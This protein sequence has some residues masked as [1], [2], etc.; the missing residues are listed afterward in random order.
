[1]YEETLSYS[2]RSTWNSCRK[3]Y[4]YQYVKR[5][6]TAPTD[7][8]VEKWLQFSKGS[9]VHACLESVFKGED[10]SVGLTRVT[11]R[12]E[13]DGLDQNKRDALSELLASSRQIAQSVADWLPA[14][15]WDPVIGPDGYKLIE[16]KLT[17]KLPGW[18]GGFVGYADLIA[19]HRP[20]GLT[21]ILDWKTRSKF[22]AEN[23]GAYDLQLAAYQHCA[24]ELGIKVHGTALVEIKPDLPK[25]APRFKRDDSKSFYSVRESEDGRIR[26]TPTLRSEELVKT[27][28]TDFEREAVSI[29]KHHRDPA[30]IY[31]NT[32]AWNCGFCRFRFACYSE[33]NNEDSQYELENRYTVDVST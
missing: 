25:R 17:A 32:S 8:P 16:A 1:M 9:A 13:R 33:A 18:P 24:T 3:R 22:D 12:F 31:R 6:R 5:L 4:E 29:A 15:D 21:L 28:W 27:L 2:R 7:L 10:M 11:E 30:E 19:T 23:V 14:S 26:F 20:T